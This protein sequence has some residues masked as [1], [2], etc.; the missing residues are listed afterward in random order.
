MTSSN[1]HFGN[2]ELGFLYVIS[3]HDAP[4]MVKIGITQ[5]PEARMTELEPQVVWARVL[6]FEPRKHEQR[7][8]AKYAERW[9][10]GT[11]W[12]RIE[13][14]R[15]GVRGDIEFD[16]L[17]KEVYE[18]GNEVLSLCMHHPN[19]SIPEHLDYIK[20]LN[21]QQMLSAATEDGIKQA[22]FKE[23]DRLK[24]E[25]KLLQQQLAELHRRFP[26]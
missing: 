25:V 11:E 18:I 6:C 22:A 24:A 3:H 12:F 16:E 10:P 2:V 23:V 7:L 13:T 5:R 8:H 20:K 1:P 17:L 15:E 26:R 4:G 19:K 9:L 14:G 21:H